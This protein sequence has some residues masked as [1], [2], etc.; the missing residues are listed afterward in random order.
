[1]G[2]LALQRLMSMQRDRR[3]HQ[4]QPHRN[5][6]IASL[7]KRKELTCLQEDKP[8]G[9][10]LRR[11][12]PSLPEK[13]GLIYISL[14][15]LRDAARAAC[16][17][18]LFQRSWKCH[19][20]L[21][22][23]KETIFNE[24]LYRKN[25]T[26]D[27][28]T[29][30][31]VKALRLVRIIY[32]ILK[33]HSGNGVKALR[34]EIDDVANISACYLNDW[35]HLAVK[36]GIEELALLLHDDLD[37]NF[38]YSVLLNGSANTIRDLRLSSCVFRPVAGF[39]SCLRS[40]TSL[41]LSEVYITGDELG[42]LL[43]S[44][45]ALEELV[46]AYCKEITCLK[47][48]CVLQ[49]L[50]QLV[51]TDCENLEVIKSKA[52]NLTVFE[53]TG[54]VVEVSIGDAVLD[55]MISASGWNV[56]HYARAK[57]PQMVPNLETL[58]ITSSLA[59]D[60]PFLPGKF[61]HLKHLCISFMV[62][63]GAFCPDYDYFSLVSFLDACPS[64]ETLMLSVTQEIV[65]HDSV[66]GDSSHLRQMPGHC[67]ASIKDVKIIGFCSAISM[68]ELTVHILE[69][70]V[71]LERLTLD[72]VCYDLRCSDG[73]SKCSVGHKNMITEAHK[74]LVV[75]RSYIL[76][77]VPSTVE[78]NVVGPCSQCHAVEN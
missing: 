67:H 30:N 22:F 29:S 70:A 68:V 25:K 69:N 63:A 76:E 24:N 53:Y 32:H 73:A 58:D 41:E 61:L 14:L 75:V 7:A 56:V 9:K 28:T 27:E 6:L 60:I 66:L 44:S 26:S 5:G 20:D 12:G 39:S 57:L 4:I 45:F 8:G 65:E 55:I 50:S 64:L 36:P 62:S 19:P 78:L 40:L 46:L 16:V 35:L 34:L 37:Y 15:S 21:T 11:L 43:S 48:P 52:P 3:H 10:K 54:G 47:I 38:P 59:T 18:H 33:N 23:S 13:S 49:R 17:S 1:M 2:L 72:T 51:V 42:C 31:G 71:S 74:A 77:K